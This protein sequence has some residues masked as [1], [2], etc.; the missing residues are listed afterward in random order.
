MAGFGSNITPE[1]MLANSAQVPADFADFANGSGP[2]LVSTYT[3]DVRAP[4]QAASSPTRH[5]A[6]PKSRPYMS[7]A[8][9]PPI[10]IQAPTSNYE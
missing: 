8:Q 2:N 10:A 4:C 9:T 6:G 5:D 3:F 7:R 1:A